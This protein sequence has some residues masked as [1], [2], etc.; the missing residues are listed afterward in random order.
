MSDCV[1]HSWLRRRSP[2]SVPTAQE[3]ER[4]YGIQIFERGR[5]GAGL[6]H[7]CAEFIKTAVEVYSKTSRIIKRSGGS[8]IVCPSTSALA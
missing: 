1:G 7:D 6:T 4:Q 5:Y 2:A 8:A 3:F